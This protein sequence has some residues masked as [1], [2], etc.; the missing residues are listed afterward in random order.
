MPP[1]VFWKMYEHILTEKGLAIFEEDAL[2][3]NR[4]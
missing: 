3:D 2:L 1:S 4:I